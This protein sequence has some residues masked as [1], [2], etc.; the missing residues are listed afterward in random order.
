MT[1]R[2]YDTEFIGEGWTLVAV[3]EL[4]LELFQRP[5]CF[6]ILVSLLSLARHLNFSF[7][8]N[9]AV[10]FGPKTATF[11]FWRSGCNTN[12]LGAPLLSLLS[13]EQGLQSQCSVHRSSTFRSPVGINRLGFPTIVMRCTFAFAESKV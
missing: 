5:N 11:I 4:G 1:V 9:V 2:F 10:C 7:R 6:Y 13:R 3:G 8:A 12:I